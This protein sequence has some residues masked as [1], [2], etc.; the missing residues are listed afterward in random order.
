MASTG[1]K[2]L[3]TTLDEALNEL[4]ADPLLIDA[5]GDLLSSS[6]LAIKR[7]EVAAYSNDSEEAE[8]AGH[9]YKY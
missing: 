5:L 6:Y 4:E 9:F 8:I 1:I 3:P 7:S 2:R